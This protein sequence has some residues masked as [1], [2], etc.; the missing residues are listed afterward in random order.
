MRR[1]GF[2]VTSALAAVASAGEYPRPKPPS[3]TAGYGQHIQRTTTLLATSA[4]EKRNKACILFY[5]QSITVLPWWKLVEAD[6]RF[7]LA[8]S[9]TGP[10]GE[11]SAKERFVSRLGRVVIEPDDWVFAYDRKVS[12]KPAR[13]GLVVRWRVKPLFL[14][15][16][17]PPKADDA[18]REHSFVLAQGLPN[19]RHKLELIGK[20][21]IKAIRVHTP[22]LKPRTEL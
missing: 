4:P 14:D 21:A 19:A 9:V 22:P 1:F 17:A 7:S 8:G 15:T 12:D 2:C 3:D 13:E 20:A 6:L 18:S 11:G 16:L 10:D 5:G